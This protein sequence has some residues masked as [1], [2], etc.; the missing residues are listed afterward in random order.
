M[1]VA[2]STSDLDTLNLSQA[3]RDTLFNRCWALLHETSPPEKK[4]DRVLDLRQ[5]DEVTL[6]AMVEVIQRTFH[7]EGITHLRWEHPPSEPTKSTTPEAQPLVE[8]LQ[9]LFPAVSLPPES[10]ENKPKKEDV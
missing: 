5:G 4:E 10:T 9:K 1:V 6:E 2:L 8:R 3:V 7:E